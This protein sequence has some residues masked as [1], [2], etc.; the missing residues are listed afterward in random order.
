MAQTF[1]AQNNP[2]AEKVLNTLLNDAKT[3][4]IRSNFT[5]TIKDKK[6]TQTAAGNFTLKGNKFVLDM[7]EMKV[8]FDGK[9]Q[10]SLIVP[11]KEVSISEPSEKELAETNPMAIL[12]GFKAKSTIQFSQK[13]KSKQNHCIELTPKIANK[14][15]AKIEVQVNKTNNNIVSI[16]ITN[17]NGSTSLLSLN[18]FQKGIKVADNIFTFNAAKHKGVLVNDLR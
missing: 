2:Q 18:N 8:W 7:I 3:T 1:S 15:L 6:N 10:W 17:K 9:T 16:R 13:T 5:M 14:D 4:A 12:S 11:S